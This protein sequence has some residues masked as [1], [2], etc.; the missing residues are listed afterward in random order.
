MCDDTPK[1]RP[2]SFPL[3]WLIRIVP[4]NR[5]GTVRLTSK[6][7]SFGMPS[8]PRLEPF[9]AGLFLSVL[10]PGRECPGAILILALPFGGEGQRTFQCFECDRPDP[11]KPDQVTGWLKGEL[12]PPK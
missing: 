3:D 4:D 8:L 1:H 9:R 12:Q 7:V 5:E 10:I 2:H 6:G 11:L